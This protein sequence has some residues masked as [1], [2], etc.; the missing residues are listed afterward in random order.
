MD[1][2]TNS[3]YPRGLVRVEGQE[4]S[5]RRDLQRRKGSGSEDMITGPCLILSGREINR[6]MPC[7]S[8]PSSP[9]LA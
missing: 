5:M 1:F 4:L 2:I 7:S 3:T 8:H 9:V 6:R